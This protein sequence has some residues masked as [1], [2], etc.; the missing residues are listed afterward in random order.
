[1]IMNNQFLKRVSF[2]V[3]RNAHNI[4]LR[5]TLCGI[6]KLF[7]PRPDQSYDGLNTLNIAKEENEI[8]NDL[9]IDGFSD[10]GIALSEDQINSIIRNLQGIDCYDT[11]KKD[12]PKVDLT[13]PG[14]DVQLAH[15]KRNDLIDF[16]EIVKIV[17]DSKILNA[18]SKYLG[19]K[20]TVSNINCWWSFGNRESAK[21][22]QFYHR[23]LD[24]YKFLKL[25]FYLTDVNED[26][27][28]HIYV[29]GS[30]RSNKLI[31]LRRFTD[32]EVSKSFTGDK[33]TT[34]LK[35]R[36]A[37]FLEDTYG[38][39]KGQLPLNGN[40]LIL[41]VQYSYLP[42]F[43]EKYEPKGHELRKSLGLD[44]YVNRLLFKDNF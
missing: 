3:Q 6:H 16:P 4:H 40:R 36:G 25:F 22:A 10:L 8:V 14:K 41:Q 5:D 20:P 13:S 17:N 7:L 21:E 38:I 44:K 27:G 37:C 35:K 33:I 1:M 32:D 30:H 42:L 34:L 31:D 39:H 26:N 15:Y 18:V 23:D 9:S 28:P 24:D 12:C 43:V 2:H 19:V 29:K 11:A